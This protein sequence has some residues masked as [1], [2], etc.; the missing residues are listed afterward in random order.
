MY[1]G[2][3]HEHLY[4]FFACINKKISWQISACQN[5]MIFFLVLANNS[6]VILLLE[7]NSA[8]N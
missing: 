6:N 3:S 1:H 8:Y 7:H 2:R 5:H 4:L